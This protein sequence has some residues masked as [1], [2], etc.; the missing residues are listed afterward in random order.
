MVF[1]FPPGPIVTAVLAGLAFINVAKSLEIV[2]RSLHRVGI[3]NHE[4]PVIWLLRRFVD[5]CCT[6]NLL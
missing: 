4:Q 6:S 1:Q 5:H 3:N 2:M